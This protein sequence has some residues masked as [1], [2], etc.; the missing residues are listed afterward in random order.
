MASRVREWAAGTAVAAALF[1]TLPGATAHP[2]EPLTIALVVGDHAQVPERVLT[3]AKAEAARIYRS[4]GIEL[5][6]SDTLDFSLPQMIVNIVAKPTGASPSVPESLAVKSKDWRVLGVAPGHKERGD[7]AA[8]AFYERILDVATMLGVDP[9]LLLGH[10]IAHEMGHCYS[11]RL[12][13][14]NG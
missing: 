8:W 5:V 7:L 4:A 14:A 10:V 1:G 9:G 3:C 2:V 6:W 12:S 13:F 11:V